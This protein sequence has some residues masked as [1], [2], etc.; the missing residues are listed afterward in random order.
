MLK[1]KIDSVLDDFHSLNAKEALL[2]D[3][4]RQVGKT[5]SIREFGKRHFELIV[6][7]N[8]IKTTGA[9]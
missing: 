8:F 9:K 5:S 7:I 1:R 4:A 6:E 2:V 3:G